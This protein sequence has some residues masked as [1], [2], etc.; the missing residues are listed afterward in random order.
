MKFVGGSGEQV[1]RAKA[2]YQ[3]RLTN[4]LISNFMKLFI[5]FKSF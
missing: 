2:A 1:K 3:T 4:Y 5:N